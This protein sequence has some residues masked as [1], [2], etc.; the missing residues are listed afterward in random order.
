MTVQRKG[1]KGLKAIIKSVK[2]AKAQQQVKPP[3]GGYHK[4]SIK[5]GSAGTVGV[6]TPVITP[7]PPSAEEAVRATT[8]ALAVRAA[9]VVT[10]MV[11]DEPSLIIANGMLVELKTLTKELDE[12][13]KF[14]LGPLKES[15]KR[16]E[17]EFKHPAQQ[18]FDADRELRIKVTSYLVTKNVAFEQKK[19]A[20][21]TKAM[22]AAQQGDDIGALAAATEAVTISAGPK[23]MLVEGAGGASVRTNMVDAFD[24]VDYGAVPHEFFTLDEKKI[25]LAVRS[26]RRDIPGIR[27]YKK[28]QLAVGGV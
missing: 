28:P 7:V 10:L 16:L 8:S 26:G 9:A 18:L 27:V 23:T 1:K 21:E 12:K 13:K 5:I 20:L 11:I 19:V 6:V 3:S 25:M 24:V 2:R 4:R 22:E 15:L 17:A 14:F